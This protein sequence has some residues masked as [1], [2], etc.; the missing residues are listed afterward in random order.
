M[1]RFSSGPL[2]RC[3]PPYVHHVFAV[4]SGWSDDLC[5]FP[6][7]LVA[8]KHPWLSWAKRRTGLDFLWGCM[9]TS[10]IERSH[11][12]PLQVSMRIYH[13]FSPYLE[14]SSWQLPSELLD[15]LFFN[16]DFLF[17]YWSP[18]EE[19]WYG[20]VWVDLER[21]TKIFFSPERLSDHLFTLAK[22]VS[23]LI[24]LAWFSFL[25]PLFLSPLVCLQCLSY[26]SFFFLAVFCVL[27][28][29]YQ[30]FFLCSFFFCVCIRVVFSST[31]HRWYLDTYLSL[32]THHCQYT[33]LPIQTR[34]L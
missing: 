12:S 7:Y 34:C 28:V 20:P 31:P 11:F 6:N 33:Y 3:Q 8:T 25:L 5:L 19:R 10:R 27:S 16:R 21:G 9:K 13:L 22:C 26:S 32:P 15:S 24:W 30:F 14:C 2:S 1:L 29:I 4:W 23:C 18:G 17:W